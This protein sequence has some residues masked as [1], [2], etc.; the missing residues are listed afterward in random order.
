MGR[1]K[2]QGNT[3]EYQAEKNILPETSETQADDIDYG[4]PMNII[5]Q[6]SETAGHMIAMEFGQ[7]KNYN[8]AEMEYFKAENLCAVKFYILHQGANTR[9][10]HSHWL[11]KKLKAGWKY[12]ELNPQELRS[13][14]L[15]PF[16][17]L[18]DRERERLAVFKAEAMAV[19]EQYSQKMVIGE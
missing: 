1:V 14:K 18:P 2:K 15:L 7:V 9:Q 3:Q 17:E 11:A 10:F 19:L 6:A 8:A 13:P 4:Y 16:N 5:E 12:G